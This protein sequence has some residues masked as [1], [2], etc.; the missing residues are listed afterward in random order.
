MRRDASNTGVPVGTVL[1]PSS[2][3]VVTTDGTVLDAKDI[4][5]SVS[6]KANNVTI[7]RSIITQNADSKSY[8]IRVYS[9]FSG[10]VVEDTTIIGSG[11]ASVG[12]CCN[13]FTLRRVDLSNTIDGVRAD[14]RVTIEQ[15][16]IHHLARLPGSHNDTIQTLKGSDI[17]IRDNT[18]SPYNTMTE[19]SMN[20]AYI[21]SAGVSGGPV[22]RVTFT[23]NYLNGG[24]YTVYMGAGGDHPVTNVTVAGNTWGRDFRYGPVTALTSD[25]DWDRATNVWEDTGL[26]V[27]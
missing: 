23:G 6:I 22:D 7:R 1:A 24:N 12:I 9:G 5:G 18:L 19:D 13:S 3:V 15:S 2:S 8:P 25:A 14:G 17:V 11:A 10:L 27:R 20:A 4:T 21:I 16:Y 26:P